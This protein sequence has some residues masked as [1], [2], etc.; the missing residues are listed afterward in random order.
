[1]RLLVAALLL[2]TLLSMFGCPQ[3]YFFEM[4]RKSAQHTGCKVDD[5]VI[6]DDENEVAEGIHK[7]K[8]ECAGKKYECTE[9]TKKSLEC[10]P[11]PE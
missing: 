3:A 5:L 9:L 11:I 10:H 1:M 8:V 6:M 2:L 4:K 7:W